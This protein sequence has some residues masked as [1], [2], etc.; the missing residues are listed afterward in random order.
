MQNKNHDLAKPWAKTL[1]Q[2]YGTAQTY[3]ILELDINF[4]LKLSIVGVNTKVT[5]FN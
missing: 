4:V 5:Q 2:C 3:I 1:E